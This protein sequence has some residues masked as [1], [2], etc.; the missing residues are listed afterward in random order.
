[1]HLV[2]IIII[3]LLALSFL[4]AARVGLQLPPTDN[5]SLLLTENTTVLF[6]LYT[7]NKR[8]KAIAYVNEEKLYG[9]AYHVNYYTIVPLSKVIV[10]RELSQENHSVLPISDDAVALNQRY[11]YMLNGS[12]LSFNICLSDALKSSNTKL[13]GF[14]TERGYKDYIIDS[15]LTSRSIYSADFRIGSH[16]NTICSMASFKATTNGYFFFVLKT[17]YA[18]T[19][20]D[21]TI[22]AALNRLSIQDY[23]SADFNTCRVDESQPS[24]TLN[25]G[26]GKW[27]LIG[28]S[29][30]NYNFG[31]RINHVQ[32]KVSRSRDHVTS[33]LYNS[34]YY[35]GIGL[36]CGAMLYASFLAI[37]GLIGCLQERNSRRLGLVNYY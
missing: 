14:D 11:I 34:F 35:G 31:S 13:Y 18:N 19:N 29:D 12:M 5:S 25:F 17:K 33:I 32:V 37:T 20:L 3:L 4:L 24:C 1:M 16:N 27:A 30:M 9:D 23:R 36:F 21:Y 2:I 22:K 7:I 26:S 15:A 6:N 10:H 8:Q 28:A